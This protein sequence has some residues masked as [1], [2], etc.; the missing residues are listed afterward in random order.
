[1]PTKLSPDK[2]KCSSGFTS[3]LSPSARQILTC[4]LADRT[5]QTYYKYWCQ[6]SAFCNSNG[7]QVGF[8]IAEPCLVNF[9]ANLFNLGYG[10]NTIA[11]HVSALSYIQKSFG[12]DDCAHSFLV[13]QFLK[14]ANKLL[15]MPRD[16][17]LPITFSILTQ[18]SA[19]LPVTVPLLTERL[20]F[21]AMALMAFY[22]FLR[23]GEIAAKTQSDKTNIIQRED[24]HLI[25]GQTGPQGIECTLKTFKHSSHPVTLFI[26]P[27]VSDKRLCPVAAMCA[28]FQL[29]KHT[30]GPLFQFPSGECVTYSF[31]N[32]HLRNTIQYLGYN[33]QYYKS[34]SFRI[35][36]ATYAC[37]R[38]YS[39]E[40]IKRMG[41]WKSQALQNYIRLPSIKLT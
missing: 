4:A 32:T 21:L 29:S 39:E 27:N 2:N 19:A 34:H 40:A 7:Y 28:Y 13:R 5:K 18:L 37:Q 26:P 33:P 36:A 30:L 9:L 16:T 23:I 41:R 8:P 31:F 35:G 10:V 14:G 1:M 25:P 12:F 15:P 38:G 3:H 6:Y 24:V 11:S 20:I 22:G 17:R